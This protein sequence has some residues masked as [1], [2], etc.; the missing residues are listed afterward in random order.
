MTKGDL[1]SITYSFELGLPSMLLHVLG[2]KNSLT[3][4]DCN[5][6][7]LHNLV[8]TAIYSLRPAGRVGHTA[9][10]D[11]PF[12]LLT[13]SPR[14]STFGDGQCIGAGSCQTRD[15][16]PVPLGSNVER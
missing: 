2:Y 6:I 13:L 3:I 11:W 8:R 7:T 1:E 5:G 16:S 4:F 9:N 12:L 10:A 15:A 14:C